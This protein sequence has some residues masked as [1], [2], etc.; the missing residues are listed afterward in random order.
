MPVTLSAGRPDNAK[1]S[2]K[3]HS[4]LMTEPA[5]CNVTRTAAPRALGWAV[6]CAWRHHLEIL[7]VFS[8][9]QADSA[10]WGVPRGLAT[11]ALCG[12]SFLSR[13]WT[14]RDP[15]LACQQ[16]PTPPSGGSL[17][18]DVAMEGWDQVP[19]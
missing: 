7:T 15:S 11:P 4:G 8:L 3:E 19:R 12:P 5:S 1:G 16:P 6:V 18:V 2:W 10:Q 17:D 13:F 14:T 9:K